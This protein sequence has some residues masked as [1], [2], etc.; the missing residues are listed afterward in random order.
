MSKSWEIDR[1]SQFVAELNEGNVDS[2]FQYMA[3]DYSHH[4]PKNDEPKA[5]EVYYSLLS[6]L[7][8]AM[9][10]LNIELTDLESNNDLITGTMTVNGTTEGPLW[11]APATNKS[12]FWVVRVMIWNDSGRFKV[13]FDGV[14]VPELIGALRQIDLVPPA[15]RM[16]K[17]HEYPVQMPEPILQVLFS[18]GM[19]EK[20]C[21]HLHNIQVYETDETECQQC[22][23]QG[24]FW[25]A[26]RMCLICGFVGCCDTSKNKHMK[27]HYLET[28]HGLFRSVRLEES[29][30]WCYVDDAFLSSRRLQK[31]YPA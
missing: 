24:D 10:D 2:V 17:P 31:H 6:D 3:A 1:L 12:F 8:V 26:L 29:W 4:S 30:G 19:A 27:Q 14:S 15:D 18:G 21:S 13:N 22:V 5:F 11:G 9:P 20:E 16:D 23:A 25:P 7:W 28:G